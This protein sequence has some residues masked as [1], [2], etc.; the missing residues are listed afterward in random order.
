MR[1]VLILL[2]IAL[3]ALSACGG[4]DADSKVTETRMDDIDSVE[5]TISDEM[6]PTDEVTEM[7]PVEASAAPAAATPKADEKASTDKPAAP[8][9]TEPAPKAGE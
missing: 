3:P 7:A 1:R 6:I 9:T 8:P 2:A 4:N 5:G